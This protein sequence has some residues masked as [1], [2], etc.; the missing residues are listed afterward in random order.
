MSLVSIATGATGLSGVPKTPDYC[1]VARAEFSSTVEI[2]RAERWGSEADASDLAV[3]NG[4]NP[5]EAG[6]QRSDGRASPRRRIQTIARRLGVARNT[7]RSAVHL[8]EPP[9]CVRERRGDRW[10]SAGH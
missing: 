4:R 3:V 9:S 6:A 7:V 5:R 8:S 1:P 10:L 2:P